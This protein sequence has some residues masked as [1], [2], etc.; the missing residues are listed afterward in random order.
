MQAQNLTAADL[1]R[2]VFPA[3]MQADIDKTYK[4][5]EA[6]KNG[7]SRAAERVCKLFRATVAPP[8]PVVEESAPAT[9][10]ATVTVDPDGS[11]HVRP[12][13]F[14]GAP[15]AHPSESH[16]FVL[17]TIRKMY[18][19]WKGGPYVCGNAYG[20]MNKIDD[21]LKAHGL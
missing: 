6:G 12:S 16:E 8:A 5:I 20:T 10:A 14:P 11:V 7:R 15:K 1:S 18:N 9:P 17:K 13:S 19:D 21:L 3:T 2:V 4:W